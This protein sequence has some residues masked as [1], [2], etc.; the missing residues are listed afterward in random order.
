MLHDTCFWILISLTTDRAQDFSVGVSVCSSCP[1]FVNCL[2]LVKYFLGFNFK[3]GLIWAAYTL[4]HQHWHQLLN[5]NVHDMARSLLGKGLGEGE[6]CTQ[7]R[8]GIT[9]PGTA[10]PDALY[11]TL[12]DFSRRNGENW[13]DLK[14]RNENWIS[15]S[16]KHCDLWEGIQDWMQEVE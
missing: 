7:V 9:Q 6:A 16:E 1:Y 8:H 4:D 5:W 12:L 2:W 11:A 15:I 14:L 3:N 13:Q 10:P